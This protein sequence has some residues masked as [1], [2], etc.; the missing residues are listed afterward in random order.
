MIA[1]IDSFKIELL[2][3]AAFQ[4]KTVQNYIS[5][6]LE[7]YKYLKDDLK[8]D[9]IKHGE[10]YVSQW[11]LELKKGGISKSRFNHHQSALKGFGCGY[12]E[13]TNLILC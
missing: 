10:K 11:F 2:E 8:L 5:C 9:P 12:F 13:T 1:L 7:Y 4:N 6:I 3:V